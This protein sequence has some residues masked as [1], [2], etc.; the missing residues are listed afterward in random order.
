MYHAFHIDS[1]LPEH[2]DLEVSYADDMVHSFIGDGGDDDDT[3]GSDEEEMP[4][5]KT[6]G[7]F[8]AED[9]LTDKCCVAYESAL[10]RL[11]SLNM[12]AL[13]R[14]KGCRNPYT[15]TTKRIG[16]SIHLIWV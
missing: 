3:S 5:P 7:T 1:F 16:T 10:L 9:I 13:C 6:S 11:A 4:P 12:P 8:S 15:V 14:V 2:E